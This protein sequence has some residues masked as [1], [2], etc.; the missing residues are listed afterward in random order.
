MITAGE[1]YQLF[2]ASFNGDFGVRAAAEV[3]LRQ[4]EGTAGFVGVV[5]QIV[6]ADESE[7]AVRQAAAI[8]FKNAV[9]RR[10]AV[11]APLPQDPQDPTQ[12]A[13]PI[14]AGDKIFIKAQILTAFV[15]CPQSVRVQ[16]Q[17]CLYTILSSDYP[18][19][20]PQFPSLLM[21]MLTSADPLVVYGG[22]LTL[23]ELV[24]VFQCV[25]HRC[26]DLY[27]PK[28]HHQGI[29]H[30][31]LK[32]RWKNGEARAPLEEIITS[33]FPHVRAIAA[34][35][36][37]SP[38]DNTHAGFMLKTI[39]KLYYSSII[40]SL[41]PAQQSNDSLVPWGTVLI[42]T[43]NKDVLDA[44]LPGDDDEERGKFAWWKAKKWACRAMNKLF[45]KYVYS[46]HHFS[47]P[48]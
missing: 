42:E 26:L 32:L 21:Q 12:T 19:L 24:K 1:A 35:L 23:L 17:S 39:L 40:Y 14:S 13:S 34:S 37:P 41:S 28:A 6:A 20:W 48:C 18:T 36:L 46:R 29:N 45:S 16:L 4:V 27:N 44:A 43:L 7:I 2:Q 10:W 38:V 15:S 47:L 11:S 30:T 22:L 8:F 3:R 9:L 33:V 5:L 25:S 31:P